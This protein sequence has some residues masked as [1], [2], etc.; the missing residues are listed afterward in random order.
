MLIRLIKHLWSTLSQRVTFSYTEESN[1]NDKEF[2]NGQVT[3]YSF[4]KILRQ[5]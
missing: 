3:A 2:M 1:I 5:Q 4:V